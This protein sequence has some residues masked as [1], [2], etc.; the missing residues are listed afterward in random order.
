ML[1]CLALALQLAL[2]GLAELNQFSFQGLAD[3][4]L[5]EGLLPNR[6]VVQGHRLGEI[7]RTRGPFR[8]IGS[9]ELVAVDTDPTFVANEIDSGLVWR[10]YP[11]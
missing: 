5:S 8:S 6:D 10:S 7:A 11:L 4:H 3:L 1:A 2:F 9:N